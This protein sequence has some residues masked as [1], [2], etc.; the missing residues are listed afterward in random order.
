MGVVIGHFTHRTPAAAKAPACPG[1]GGQ[2]TCPDCCCPGGGCTDAACCKPSAP[3]TDSITLRSPNGKHKLTLQATDRGAGLWIEHDG[4]RGPMVAIYS[5]D[6]QNGIGFYAAGSK[7]GP[8][9]IAL[10]V[11][12]KGE[13]GIQ[14][15]DSKGNVRWLTPRDVDRMRRLGDKLGDKVGEPEPEPDIRGKKD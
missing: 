2:C 7:A 14:L 10:G 8:M 1:A 5:L 6:D 4:H 3:G 13:G 15:R 12:A 9:A 11:D